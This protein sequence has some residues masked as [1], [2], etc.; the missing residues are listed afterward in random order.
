MAI[1][2]GTPSTVSPFSWWKACGLFLGLVLVFLLFLLAPIYFNY[3]SHQQRLQAAIA[4][5]RASGDPLDGYDLNRQ[6]EQRRTDPNYSA[7]YQELFSEV[8]TLSEANSPKTKRYMEMTLWQEVPSPYEHWYQLEEIEA[9]QGSLEPT[10]NRLR[11]LLD[12]KRRYVPQF[13]YA[14]PTADSTGLFAIR[15]LMRWEIAK[16]NSELYRQHWPQAF[17]RVR[18]ILQLSELLSGVN[19]SVRNAILEIGLEEM[20]KLLEVAELSDHELASM[21]EYLGSLPLE[22]ELIDTLVTDRAEQYQRW[23]TLK[24][25]DFQ[26][27]NSKPSRLAWL[28]N[29][30]VLQSRPLDCAIS[31]ECMNE[32]IELLRT[33]PGDSRLE[34]V[35][36]IAQHNGNF[37]NLVGQ[38]TNTFFYPSTIANLN[39]NC[40]LYRRLKSTTCLI[41]TAI[42]L[43]RFRTK[44]SRLP[45]GLEDLVPEYMPK[46]P[47][48]IYSQKPIIYRTIGNRVRLSCVGENQIDDGGYS[49]E[50]NMFTGQRGEPVVPG[51]VQKPKLSTVKLQPNDDIGLELNFGLGDALQRANQE[52]ASD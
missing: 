13:D 29:R 4:A 41:E 40:L 1:E 10:L 2:Q 5:I 32:L 34:T 7:E 49:E 37:Q 17:D 47:N 19:W 20:V 28:D 35:Q 21:Q 39:N 16:F 43:K 14:R 24:F 38:K 8:G 6:L 15:E 3:R 31:L 46:V 42:A 26:A 9:L 12:H 25:Q 11:M 51:K 50:L 18:R 44:Y 33:N 52:P 48:D 45:K 30:P 27:K 22:R 36:F 23:A